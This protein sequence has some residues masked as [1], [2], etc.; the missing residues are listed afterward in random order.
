MTSPAV[1][2][3]LKPT[4]VARRLG[5]SRSWLYA[6][7]ADGRIPSIRLGGPDGPLRFVPE[8]LERWI[9]EARA[10]WTPTAPKRGLLRHAARSG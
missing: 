1:I 9:E 8:D 7:A 2:D 5:V 3:L 10:A 6:A 4:D